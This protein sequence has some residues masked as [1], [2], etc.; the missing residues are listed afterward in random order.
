M[1]MT[2]TVEMDRGERVE[3]MVDIYDS[4]DTVR[5]HDLRTNTER[6]QP[7]QHTGNVSLK[8]RKHRAVEVC[9]CLLCVLLLT[10]VMMLCVYFKTERNQLLTHINNLTEE[11][12]QILT[13]YEQILNHSNNLTEEREQVKNKND[14][15]QRVLYEQDQRADNFKWIYFNFSFYYISSEMKRWSDSRRDCQQRGA[16]L[17][18]IN[19]EEE[20]EFLQKVAGYDQFWIGL[21]KT[22]G[23]WKWI[24]GTTIAKGSV[25]MNDVKRSEITEVIYDDVMLMSETVEMDRGERVEMMVDIYDSA[26]TVRHHDLRTNTERH[27]PLQHTGS[28][29]VK[30]RKHRAVEVCLCVLCVLLLTAVMMLCVYFTTERNQLLTHINNL[31]EERQ[32]ILTKY[33]QIL[34]HSNNLTEER[35]QIKNKNDELQ[36]GICEQDQRADNFK[37]IYCNFSFYYISSE[38][39]RWSDSRRDCQQRGADLVIIN[40]EEEQEFLQKVAGYDQFW[41]GLGKTEGVWKWI[42]GTT[43]V[44]GA[45]DGVTGPEKVGGPTR[46]RFLSREILSFNSITSRFRTLAVPP[47]PLGTVSSKLQLCRLSDKAGHTSSAPYD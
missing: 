3:M 2:E 8:N 34:N 5:H 36:R 35:E 13:K 33:E 7:L 25:I 28:V 42:D 26:D 20:Q 45:Q 22:E 12:Q 24:D 9:L 15:L 47:G 37:W 11:R 41:I 43:I 17:V 4:A 16:D 31:T 27:Q 21:S 46:E 38:M 32:Q 30:N 29:S 40:S 23:V 14:E 1:L 19:S 18:I 39:K 6:H 44:K 10:A